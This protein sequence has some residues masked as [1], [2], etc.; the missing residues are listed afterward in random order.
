MPVSLPARAPFA[1]ALVAAV[2][3]TLVPRLAAA[4]CDT[5]TAGEVET[6]FR[7][8]LALWKDKQYEALYVRGYLEHQAALPEED[9]VRLMR[10]EDRVLQC[11]WLTARNVRVVCDGGNVYAQATIGYEIAGYLFDPGRRVWA[12]DTVPRDAEETWRFVRQADA[13]RVDLYQ[14]LGPSYLYYEKQPGIV[15]RFDFP[16]FPRIEPRP[17][18]AP[19]RR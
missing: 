11:C 7:D 8:V 15:R 12:H 5:E 13:W 2:A 19:P 18:V 16:R 9:F 3:F 4:A 17:R 14:V 10:R 1:A 6:A